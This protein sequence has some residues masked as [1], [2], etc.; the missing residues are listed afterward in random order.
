[1][2]RKTIVITLVGLL[3]ISLVSLNAQNRGNV[4]S[5]QGV[6]RAFTFSP[7]SFGGGLDG[8]ADLG[9][10]GAIFNNPAATSGIQSIT[11]S[12]GY[13]SNQREWWEN[14][15]YKPNRRQVTMPFYLEG[16]Y[17]PDP[18]DNGKLDSDVFYESLLDTSYIVADPEMGVEHYS[19]EA[20]DWIE[21]N[22]L[23]GLSHFGIAVP[24]TVAGRS[25]TLSAGYGMLHNGI[26]FD[27]NTTYLTPHPGYIDYNMPAVV[28]G[29]DSVTINWY[30]FER[31]QAYQMNQISV[32]VGLQLNDNIHVG[33]G[34]DLFGGKSDDH[35][36]FQKVGEFELF[37]QNEF[38][39]TYDTLNTNY[40][41]EADYS[42]TRFKLGLILDYEHFRFGLAL[43]P[44]FDLTRDWSY[45]EEYIYLQGDTLLM[46]QEQTLSGQ[47]I[48]TVAPT[49]RVGVQLMPVDRFTFLLSYE[50]HPY[51]DSDFRS[52]STMALLSG[53][54]QA[55]I[56]QS[57][58]QYGF[59]FQLL[60]PVHVNFLY[61]STTQPV[62]PDGSPLKQAGPAQI[63]YRVGAE[64]DFGMFGGLDLGVEF[65]DLKY[66]DIYYTNTN[67]SR[68]QATLLSVNYS[69]SLK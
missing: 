53:D 40:S 3:L 50:L 18:A 2:T 62:V 59:S 15:N 8:V 24:L 60:D 14:Q 43:S 64:I 46:T 26:S 37:D 16:L 63:A 45:T 47:E 1:M 22:E 58:I 51:G 28:E 42:G 67:Y 7:G 32:G 17:V 36:Y 21:S 13:D 34:L 27:R 57:I 11:F 23:A 38:T 69:Y 35:Q 66:S 56:D 33:L 19:E 68:E 39:W 44:G 29:T 65:Q 25:L 52:D 54:R 61:R 55:W 31:L 9:K 5:F 20:A 4:L 6:E 49:Y 12:L 41:G 48:M 30:D 10:S